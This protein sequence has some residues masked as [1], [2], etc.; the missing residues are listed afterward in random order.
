MN[1]RD[2]QLRSTK[3]ERVRLPSMIHMNRY[4]DVSPFHHKQLR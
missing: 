1:Q 3:Q 4:N 2:R